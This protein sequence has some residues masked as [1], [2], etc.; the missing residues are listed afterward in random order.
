MMRGVRDRQKFYLWSKWRTSFKRGG[1][2]V[3][4]A[5]HFYRNYMS[6]F[7]VTGT[8]PDDYSEE[9]SIRILDCPTCTEPFREDKGIRVGLRWF[10]SN[11]CARN[12]EQK[13]ALLIKPQ[14]VGVRIGG[15][16]I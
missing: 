3:N 14:P 5:P 6:D 9:D 15:R 12:V 16:D 2:R 1:F 7:L 8:S 11:Y 13:D 4:T 10:C